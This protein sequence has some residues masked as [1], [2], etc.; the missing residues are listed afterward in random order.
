MFRWIAM[1]LSLSVSILPATAA[2]EVQA[3]SLGGFSLRI[4]NLSKAAPELA[5][6]AFTQIQRWW[7]PAH[8]YSG[9]AENLSLDVA[10]GGAFLEKLDN[11]G[12]VRHLEVVYAQPGRE[13]RLLGGLGPLQPMGLHGALSI[14]FEPAGDGSRIIMIYNV[15]G[16]SQA[17]LEGLAPIVDSVQAEQMQRHAAYADRLAESR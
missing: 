6:E 12:F 15:A 2:A 17:G 7:N 4:E 1:C 10:P 3:A 8:T 16:F 9:K 5:Y 14:Q 13:I 11:G